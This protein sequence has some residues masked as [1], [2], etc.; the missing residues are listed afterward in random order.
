MEPVDP[1]MFTLAS[2]FPL[3]CCSPV[4]SS[5]LIGEMFYLDMAFGL[6]QHFSYMWNLKQPLHLKLKTSNE[7]GQPLVSDNQLKYL[8]GIAKITQHWKVTCDGYAKIQ[9]LLSKEK[10]LQSLDDLMYMPGFHKGQ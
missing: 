9:Q 7:Q 4:L 8:D 6:K 3:M 10:R 5:K 2:E 1:E